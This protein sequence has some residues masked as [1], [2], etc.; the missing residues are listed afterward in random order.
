MAL[1]SEEISFT[2]DG[3]GDATVYSSGVSGRIHRIKYGKGDMGGSTNLTITSETHTDSIFAMAVGATDRD[4][5]PRVALVGNTGVALTAPAYDHYIV[6]SDDR[7]KVVIDTGGATKTGS[8]TI[9][10]EA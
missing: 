2:T 4:M 7:L 1:H 8:V 5:Y 3:S 6:Q 10:Y 9:F